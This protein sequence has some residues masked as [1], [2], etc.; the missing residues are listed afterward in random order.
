MQVNQST[1]L[2][3]TDKA[4]AKIHPMEESSCF[5]DTC[6]ICFQEKKVEKRQTDETP[7]RRPI[8][9]QQQQ[10]WQCQ[11]CLH[12][13]R[14]FSLKKTALLLVVNAAVACSEF[15]WS[16]VLFGSCDG[17]ATSTWVRVT[18]PTALRRVQLPVKT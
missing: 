14:A 7:L 9:L 12:L 10:N 1:I 4:S 15:I 13:Q 3:Q 18:R 6:S 11:H 16:M 2:C 5:T 17:G 8:L